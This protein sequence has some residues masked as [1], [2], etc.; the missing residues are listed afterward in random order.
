MYRTIEA[1]ANVTSIPG[2]MPR[3]ENDLSQELM[4]ADDVKVHCSPRER[5]DRETYVFRE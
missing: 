1:V 5:H 2:T 3:T 4:V